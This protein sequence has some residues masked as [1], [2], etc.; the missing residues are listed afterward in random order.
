M[1]PSDVVLVS[2]VALLIAAFAAFFKDAITKVPKVVWGWVVRRCTYSFTVTNNQQGFELVAAWLADKAPRPRLVKLHYSVIEDKF[3]LLPGQGLHWL[4]FNGPVWILHGCQEKKS[5]WG[6]NFKEESYTVT[7][8]GFRQRR[9]F[10]FLAALDKYRKPG[11]NRLNV[12]VWQQSYWRWVGL[13][14]KRPLST[15]YMPTATRNLLLKTIDDFLA[16][17]EWYA[18]RGIP[19][20]LGLSLEGPTG[21]GKTTAATALAGHYDRPVY[22]ANL[23]TFGTDETV[24]RA[25]NEVPRDGII[26]IEDIDTFDTSKKR[27]GVE[28]PDAPDEEETPDEEEAEVENEDG[29]KEM[30]KGTVGGAT[31]DT[32]KKK[33]VDGVTLSGLLNAIDGIAAT[34]GR[35]LIITTNNAANLDPALMREGR[36]RERIF[37]GPLEPTDIEHM[38]TVFYE[39]YTPA[40]KA[41]VRQYASM[42]SHTAAWWQKLFIDHRDAERLM[43]DVVRPGLGFPREGR[44]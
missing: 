23:K 6:G 42:H 17:E 26:L 33:K 9:I 40:D 31:P 4:W 39:G 21:T 43:A 20:R 41:A 35:I 36:I 10:D 7:L 44:L 27:A 25:F 15:V 11:N 16:S 13:K 30:V 38:F 18:V 8:F 37:I 5:E 29:S 34:E 24:L 14:R 2:A 12:F 32:E 1:T 28:N 22:C 3:Q 19:W